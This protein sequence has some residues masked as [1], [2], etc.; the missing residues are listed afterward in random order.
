MKKTWMA[1]TVEKDGKRCAY[2]IGV[3]NGYDN[4]WDVL[5]NISG[6][7]SVLILDTKAEALDCANTWN[8]VW[9]IEDR[10]WDCENRSWLWV[11]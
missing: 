2:A 10:F 9:Q 11:Y 6:L 8:E 7:E 1:V 3:R 5:S 4:A